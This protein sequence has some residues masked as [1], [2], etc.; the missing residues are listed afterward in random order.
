MKRIVPFLCIVAVFCSMLIFVKP[1]EVS[2]ASSWDGW[3]STKG[4]FTAMSDG[5]RLMSGDCEITYTYSRRPEKYAIEFSLQV[6]KGSN[7][8]GIQGRAEGRRPGGYIRDGYISSMVDGAR[9]PITGNYDGA[10]HTYC[11]EVDHT[12]NIQTVYYDGEY[13]GVHTLLEPETNQNLFYTDTFTFW[14]ANGGE[15]Q[16]KDVSITSLMDDAGAEIPTEYTEAYFDDFYNLDLCRVPTGSRRKY[17]VHDAEAGT[18]KIYREKVSGVSTYVEH[19]LKARE[20]FDLEFRLKRIKV[21]ESLNQSS[22]HLIVA[23]DSRYTWLTFDE[24]MIEF[25]GYGEYKRDV[26]YDGPAHCVPYALGYDWFELKGEFRDSWV[27]WYIKKD[28]ETEYKELVTYRV[29]TVITDMW[30]VGVGANYGVANKSGGVVMD[31]QRYTPYD[32]SFKITSPTPNQ[33]FNQGD[34]IT[35]DVNL[36]GMSNLLKS[37]D[38]YL[39]GFKVGTGRYSGFNYTLADAQPGVYSLK[40]VCSDGRE[41]AEVIFEVKKSYDTTTEQKITDDLGIAIVGK[42]DETWYTY[43]IVV[44]DF[45]G[46]KSFSD[47]HHEFVKVYRKVRGDADSQ[48]EELMALRTP[49]RYTSADLEGVDYLYKATYTGMAD[50]LALGY[51]NARMDE[52][53]DLK[54]ASEYSLDNLQFA[55]ELAYSGYVTK[56]DAEIYVDSNEDI[57]SVVL[58]SYDE[59]GVMIDVDFAELSGGTNLA[60]LNIKAGNTTKLFIWSNLAG[61]KPLLGNPIEIN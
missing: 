37:V 53:D 57:E 40:A 36:S 22:F 2:A 23:T 45:D 35:F 42:A 60:D 56:T 49:T 48:Y 15:M 29:N 4:S 8:I 25:A 19:P 28:G 1:V 30:L 9:I 17:F 7:S 33:T 14:T 12:Q 41:S 3:T 11:F 52:D 47:N 21:D 34:N 58:A 32:D 59:N 18:V 16:V 55:E 20:N 61:G 31:W 54:A 27:T 50:R 6:N 26:S 43:K 51:Y 39:N 44:G 38:Y 5:S 13:V 10:Y 46:S 24:N